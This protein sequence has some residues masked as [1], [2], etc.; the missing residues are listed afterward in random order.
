MNNRLTLF[1]R[2]ALPI[3]I[4]IGLGASY[5]Q[6][7]P[8]NDMFANRTLIS[9]T[10][11]LVTGSNAGATREAGEP[12]HAGMNGGASVWWSW[13]AP[14]VG[15]VTIS[16]AGSSFDTLLG[17][18]TGSSVT[19][20]TEVAS[21]DDE[22]YPSISTSKA[23]FDVISNQTYQIAVDGYAGTSGSLQLSVQ[24]GPLVPPPPA[25]AWGLPDPY[26][27]MVHSSSYAGKVVVLDFW[28]T[29][30]GPCK[31]EMPD[32]VALQDNYRAD[33]LVIVG[34]DVSWSGDSSADVQTFLATWTP[35]INYQI[36]SSTLGTETAYGSIDA[37][38]TTFL[39]DRQNIIRKK[40]VGTQSRSTLEK[41]IIPLLYCNT[42]LG[43]TI[44]GNQMI[45]SWPA[46]AQTFTLES[47]LSPASPWSTWPTGPTVVNGTNTVQVPMTGSARYF[48][49]RMPY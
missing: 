6:G 34:A 18:Y 23:V 10:N 26:G 48:R 4:F 22:N 31:A 5:S 27:V 29:W 37:I 41:Q 30:C 24:L 39:I 42:C 44:A 2:F 35:A 33:G 12:Y 43:C 1:R 38:P 19:A 9:G 11:V 40:Y 21:N 36:V 28:A 15:T 14:S 13:K 7:Q 3:T 47:S 46:N 8:A 32:L 20:L 17:V 49:L 16:T 25:P 45:F